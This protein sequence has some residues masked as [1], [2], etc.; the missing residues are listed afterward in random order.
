MTT[1]NN[2][3]N[4]PNNWILTTIGEIGYTLTGNTPST[5]Y[6]EYYNGTTPFYK[7]SDLDSGFIDSSKITL[8]DIGTIQARQLP[9]DSILVTCIGS[10]IGKTAYIKKSGAFN[11]QINGVHPII[12]CPKFV[13]YQISSETFKK[14]LIEKSS[15][16]T[17]PIINKSKFDKL[18]FVLPPLKE[19]YRIV[20]KIEELFSELDKAEES[21]VYTQKQLEI[22]KQ[23]VLRDAFEGELTKKWRVI[24]GYKKAYTKISLKDCCQ[25]ITDGTHYSPKT[26][27]KGVPYITV[28]DI[29]NDTIDFINSK[30]ITKKDF[31]ILKKEGNSPKFNDVLFSKD[32][33]VGK[34][35]LVDFNKDFVVLSSLAIIRPTTKII[36]PKYLFYS[37]KS[38][39]FITQ[40]LNSKKGVAIRRVILRDL[41]ELLINITGI[42]EQ[43]QIVQEI[44]YR[45][46][47]I[48]N[49]EKS[50]KENLQ[51]IEIFRQTIYQKAFSGNLVSQ[52]AND[53]PA[54]KL[55]RRI[56]EEKQIYEK[57]QKEIAKKRVKK[58]KPMESNKSIKEILEQAKEP[59]EAKLVW[60]SSKHKNDIEKFYEELKS[61][62]KD[63]QE[64]RDGKISKLALK[65]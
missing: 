11:Q 57:K 25:L 5:K 63:I 19:Q 64:I 4:L 18:R 7:P 59:I 60:Q 38:G 23:V 26:T 2:Q 52:S 3:Y 1:K 56:K 55:L 35:A 24:K 8:S 58:I 42:E 27:S 20:E 43:Q 33:T 29:K 53:E 28:K 31:I 13:Y 47:L 36:T 10:S 14:S 62:S 34:V 9:K 50:T 51:R 65:K 17:I 12:T 46:T 30:Q 45:F 49:L 48:D 44:E 15:A 61:I 21:L 6:P 40:A 39:S 22:F 41:K 54:S 32:G 16:T 37:L